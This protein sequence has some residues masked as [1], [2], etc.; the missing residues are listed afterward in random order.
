[1]KLAEASSIRTDVGGQPQK[2]K[3]PKIPKNQI[4]RRVKLRMKNMSLRRN[5]FTAEELKRIS[6]Y[7]S[8]DEDLERF[9]TILGFYC[10][11]HNFHNFTIRKLLLLPPP[12]S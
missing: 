6:E 12:S 4:L 2:S 1:M 5:L 10:G 3:N 9:N 7:R 11:T 8:S